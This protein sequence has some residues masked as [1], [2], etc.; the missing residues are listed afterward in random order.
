M[1]SEAEKRSKHYKVGMDKGVST[2]RA[3]RE[4]VPFDWEQ[5]KEHYHFTDEQLEEWKN[6]PKKGQYIKTMCSPAIQNRTLIIEVV[7][8]HGCG[9]DMKVGDRLYFL[10][11]GQLDTARSDNWCG[12]ALG[13][14]MPFSNICHNLIMQDLPIDAMYYNVFPCG[15][16]GWKLGWGKVVMKAY[17]VDESE[18]PYPPYQPP[19]EGEKEYDHPL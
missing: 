8:S 6:H 14:C 13:S 1:A 9:N 3:E 7:D 17:V 12:H 10:G 15:D 18:G 16:T 19:A 11:G 4:A 5:M 2:T